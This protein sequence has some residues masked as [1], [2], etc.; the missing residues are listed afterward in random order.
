[1][2][3]TPD[4]NQPKLW[5]ARRATATACGALALA[6]LTLGCGGDIEARMAE[7]RALQDVGQFTA[8]IDEL[9]E[10]LA[11]SPDLPEAS[12]RLG[13]ALVQTGEPSRAVWALQKAAESP[14]Y[15]IVAGLLLASAQLNNQNYEEVVR[16]A[17][18][19]LEIDPNR[20]VA[21]QLRAKGNLGASQL[22]AALEDSRRLVELYPE[23]YS[24][25][26]LYATV[27]LDS[28]H[29]DEAKG[30]HDRIKELGANSGD[31]AIES[32]G[33]LAPALF[34]HETLED[35]DRATAL[36]ED[37]VT[38]YP[39]DSFMVSQAMKFFDGTD[40]RERS[41]K[42]IR[43]A[44]ELAPESLALR[45]SLANRLA[46]EGDPE[47]AEAVLQ[48]AVESFNSAA[49]WNMLASFHR[50]QGNADKALTALEKVIE[51]SRGGSDQLR[52]T[53]ADILV[54]L[55]ELDRAEEVAKTLGEPTYA[56]LILGRIQLKRGDARAALESFDQG[57]RNWPNNAGARY[58]AGLAARELGDFDRAISEFREAVRSDKTATDAAL[59]LALIH[60]ERGEYPQSR[61]F[62]ATALERPNDEKSPQAFVILIRTLTEL[63]NYD[64]ARKNVELLSK[65]PNQ[66][67]LAAVEGAQV[68]ARADSPAA[69]ADALRKS[70][71]QIADGDDLDLV[72]ALVSH[73]QAAERND[74]ALTEIDAALAAQPDSA[75]LHQVR[76][77][78]LANAGRNADAKAAF[79]KALA[80]DPA[81]ANATAGLATLAAEAGQLGEAVELFAKAAETSLE[82]SEYIYSAGQLAWAAGDAAAAE[83]RFREVVRISPGH[84]GARNDLAWLLAERGQD[85]D[86]ALALSQEAR[87]IDGSPEILDTL[88]WVHLK[89]GET[90]AAVTTFEEALQ[91]QPDSASIRYRLGV[92]LGQAGNAAGAREMLQGAL[93][94]GAFPEA[95]DARRELAQLDRS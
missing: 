44:V 46:A 51:L 32:R 12:Y 77:S 13:V 19:V 21:L 60:F 31:P 4:P 16:A 83:E 67:V 91:A 2:P 86:L 17:D 90:Q 87:R 58:L 63:E 23:D 37:C 8:S 62:A 61:N 78:L 39:S 28:G 69:A 26:V 59:L 71:S 92:A 73:L 56:K 66:E 70:R 25:Q 74:E 79:E 55:D 29:T 47:A 94:A 65:L 35:N 88:G 30:A 72:T 48:E 57:I 68:T 1:M 7:V 36:F 41:T 84:A 43:A 64:R 20:Q 50:R 95:E 5:R 53:H 45:S 11:I 49:A 81:D 10:I 3:C 9:R 40:R 27:L 80:I 76:G 22:E 89:R 14:S 38:K 93:D 24:V 6:W 34:A 75:R 52:F 82:P 15:A 42:L 33:C 85:L 18:R 54:D